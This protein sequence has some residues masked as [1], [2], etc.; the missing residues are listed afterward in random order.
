MIYAD[1]PRK[2]RVQGYSWSHV[3]SPN[4]GELHAFALK[5]KLTRYDSRPFPHYDVSAAELKKLKGITILKDRRL[6][7]KIMG[8]ERRKNR[9]S[10]AREQ[11]MRLQQ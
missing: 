5:N 6:I 10:K 9:Y 2:Y 3:F 7:R 4:L 1:K 11:N 8:V